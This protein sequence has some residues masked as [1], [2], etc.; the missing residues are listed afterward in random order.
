MKNLLGIYM[1]LLTKS[2]VENISGGNNGNVP[3]SGMTG[4]GGVVAGSYGGLGGMI[5][6]GMGGLIAGSGNCFGNSG[7]R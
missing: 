3:S 4:G 1:R 6:S 2:E 7:G 5:V